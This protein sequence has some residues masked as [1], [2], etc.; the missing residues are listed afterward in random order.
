[1]LA[2]QQREEKK[3]VKKGTP[4][5]QGTPA[6]GKAQKKAGAHTLPRGSHHPCSPLEQRL[7]ESRG[8]MRLFTA[9]RSQTH[10]GR[11][12][13]AAAHK[14]GETKVPAPDARLDS[15][16]SAC[17]LQNKGQGA[18]MKHS[19][20]AQKTLQS[21]KQQRKLQHEA[22]A[23]AKRGLQVG[24]PGGLAPVCP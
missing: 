22:V 5:K 21:Q 20:L 15:T 2:K 18:I 9:R 24:G 7:A 3:K 19:A 4:Q 12:T 8:A 13:G 1:V 14:G 23:N 16:A 6:G 10:A 11:P 17:C